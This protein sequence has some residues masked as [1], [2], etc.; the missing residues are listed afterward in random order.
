[1][2][3]NIGEYYKELEWLDNQT[4]SNIFDTCRFIIYNYL[5]W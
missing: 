2:S 5:R 1:M 4:Y 3:V